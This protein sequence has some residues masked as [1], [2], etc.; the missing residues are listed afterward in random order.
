VLVDRGLAGAEQNTFGPARAPALV[1]V[2]TNAGGALVVPDL[3]GMSARDALAA[4]A[5]LG[6]ST[7][8]HGGGVVA[9]QRP[10]AGVP[11]DTNVVASV[12]LSRRPDDGE[13][14]P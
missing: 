11:I 6:L 4:L 13:R 10:E 9:S 1:A 7:R 3:T 12:W 8:L 5:R 14:R 2:D